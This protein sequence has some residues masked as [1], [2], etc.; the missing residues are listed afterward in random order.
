[1]GTNTGLESRTAETLLGTQAPHS[2]PAAAHRPLSIHR[3]R[4]APLRPP[5][6]H[7]EPPVGP[8]RCTAHPAL[9]MERTDSEA[10]TLLLEA[11]PR[12]TP[13]SH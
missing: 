1:M 9:R 7:G 2:C 5:H 13:P 12:I 8:P 4:S 3:G 10:A 6:A 11:K